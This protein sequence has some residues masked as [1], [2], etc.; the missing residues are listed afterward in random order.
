MLAD[1]A[2]AFTL[3]DGEIVDAAGA[4]TGLRRQPARTMDLLRRKTSGTILRDQLACAT[5]RNAGPAT[6]S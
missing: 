2:R 3:V 1:L 6:S 5:I 4:P